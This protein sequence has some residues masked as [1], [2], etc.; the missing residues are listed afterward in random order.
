MHNMAPP[1]NALIEASIKSSF[2][3]VFVWAWP[4][5]MHI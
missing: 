4:N 1:T 3:F 5:Q 2:V